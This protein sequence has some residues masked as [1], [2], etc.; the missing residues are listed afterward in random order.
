MPPPSLLESHSCDDPT[1]YDDAVQIDYLDDKQIHFNEECESNEMIIEG[2]VSISPVPTMHQGSSSLSSTSSSSSKQDDSKQQQLQ[3]TVLTYARKDVENQAKAN[4]LDLS[5]TNNH[6]RRK[7]STSPSHVEIVTQE[8]T[9]FKDIIGHGAVKLRIDELILPL[10]LPPEIS[11]F[12]LTGIRSIPASILLYGPPG[13]GKTRLARAIA[14]EAHAAFVPVTP[15]DVLSKFVGESE[16]AVRNIFSHAVTHALTLDS[17]CAVVFF[18][19]IDALGQSRESRGTGEGEGCSRRVLAELLLQLNVIADRKYCTLQDFGNRTSY[20]Q[21]ILDEC[22]ESDGFSNAGKPEPGEKLCGVRI[23]V[24]A[25]TNR[26]FDCDSALLRRFGIQLEVGLPTFRDRKRLLLKHLSDISHSLN[27]TELSFLATVTDQWS[28]S[29]IE[30]L[31]REAAM[32]PLRECIRQAALLRRRASH[33]QNLNGERASLADP[34]LKARN[35]LLQGFQ[36]LRPVSLHDFRNAIEILTGEEL[37][38][39]QG[40]ED[41]QT[42]ERFHRVE[43]YDSSS[44]EEQ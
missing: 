11:D 10:G 26:L 44:D 40:S 24:V 38:I 6:K 8:T 20:K 37:P 21:E 42:N 30:S 17:K 4:T 36:A 27:A 16:A 3:S 1:C 12:V 33:Q 28:G 43:H 7:K 13:C 25:A 14:G 41:R 19:E 29:A 34:D 39:N 5:L 31:S 35:A 9:R 23:I 18:D 32:A 15:S 2:L 22:C